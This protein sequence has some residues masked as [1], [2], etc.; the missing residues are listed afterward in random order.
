MLSGK[1]DAMSPRQLIE[2]ACSSTPSPATDAEP[3]STPIEML[4]TT[5]GTWTLMFHGEA[6]LSDMQQSGPRGGDKLFS[7]N[8]W[9]PMAQ[10]N[11]GRGTL[12]IRTMLSFE[13]A[14][15]SDRRYPELFQQGDTAL[16]AHRGRAASPRLFM[17]L[18]ALMTTNL[19]SIRCF[20]SLTPLPWAIPRWGRPTSSG[21]GARKI[22]LRR[23]DIISRTPLT[24]GPMSLPWASPIV[25]SGSKPRD[26]MDAS[27]T[28]SLEYDSGKT[29][30]PV[31]AGH[32]R[33]R[34]ELEP[35]ISVAGAQPGG[36]SP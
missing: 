19:A 18:A 8:W 16:A 10:R 12:A 22:P 4:M 31:G 9:M 33:S 21:L 7:T 25:A 17:E 14:L 5:K 27:L 20:P 15:L 24:F 35:A 23:W 11:F 13:P 29:G 6:F 26:F 32:R 3:D 1:I 36:F 34:T 28:N 2:S 30:T